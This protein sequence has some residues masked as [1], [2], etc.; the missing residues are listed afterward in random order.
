MKEVFYTF[1]LFGIIG[2]GV[3]IILFLVDYGIKKK[4]VKPITIGEGAFPE[5]L[6]CSFLGAACLVIVG[7][8]PSPA[9]FQ[10]WGRTVILWFHLQPW[11]LVTIAAIMWIGTSSL[12]IRLMR[13]MQNQAC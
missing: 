1:L 6:V 11:I 8:I 12:V 13:Q 5:A 7:I 4:R 2:I 10:I 9:T 3:L